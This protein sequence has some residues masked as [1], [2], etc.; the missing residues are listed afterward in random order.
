MGW[1]SLPM[2]SGVPRPQTRGSKFIKSQ[3][4]RL[5]ELVRPF[6]HRCVALMQ[7]AETMFC[8]LVATFGIAVSSTA[9]AGPAQSCEPL[10]HALCS[11]G[12]VKPASPLPMQMQPSEVPTGALPRAIKV[13]CEGT[14]TGVAHPGDSV[15]LTG[16]WSPCFPPA[17][18][19]S[20]CLCGPFHPHQQLQACYSGIPT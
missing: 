18:H 1:R 3:E 14:A 20:F 13:L 6:N 7:C 5:Q 4:L 9:V 16:V 2:R 12:H 8:A 11:C 10:T 15:T 17:N 19:C